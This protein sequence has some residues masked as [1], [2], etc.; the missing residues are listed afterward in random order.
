MTSDPLKICSCG[1][2][3]RWVTTMRGKRMPLDPKP[4]PDGNVMLLPDGRARV[5][6]EASRR[7]CTEPLYRSHF[8]TCTM[9]ARFRRRP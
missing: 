9:A 8:A 6:D 2:L 1:Q 5:L 7:T 3:I 4:L